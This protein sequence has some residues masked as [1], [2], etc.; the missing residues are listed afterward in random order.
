M[1]LLPAK[2]L[3]GLPYPRTSF[4]HPDP[5][6]AADRHALEVA[7]MS[8]LSLQQNDPAKAQ[9][10]RLIGLVWWAGPGE[11]RPGG[12]GEFGPAQG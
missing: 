4:S 9:R 7:T 12:G 5:A 11:P 3:P 6:E 8:L 2:F 1:P 10:F